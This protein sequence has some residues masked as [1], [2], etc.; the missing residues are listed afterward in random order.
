M[1]LSK[2]GRSQW[3]AIGGTVGVIIGIVILPWYSISIGPF[4]ADVYAWDVN[5]WGK[6]AFI[7]M[8]L[9]IGCVVVMVLPEPP[10]LPVPV[11]IAMLAASAL[12]ALMVVIEFL[13]HNSYIGIG[14]WLTLV[15]ALVAAYGSFEMGGRLSLPTGTSSSN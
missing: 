1:D 3:L 11:P 5:I 14:F 10:A 2:I 15:A 8:L 13:D 7:G 4:S 12:T 9:M 6:L